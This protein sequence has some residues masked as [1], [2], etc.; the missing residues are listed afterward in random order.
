MM[1]DPR[2]HNSNTDLRTRWHPRDKQRW[3][4]HYRGQVPDRIDPLDAAYS[5]KSGVFFV[6]HKD[7]KRCFSGF[8]QARY[9]GNMGYKTSWYDIENEELI[10]GTTKSPER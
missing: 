5:A 6:D 7:F 8:A 10:L 3:T 4:D 9:K 1:R 2:G